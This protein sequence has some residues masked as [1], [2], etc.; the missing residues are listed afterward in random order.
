MHSNYIT[1]IDENNFQSVVQQSIELPTVF[2]F[3]ANV[4]PESTALMQV[5]EKIA[6]EYAGAFTLATIDCEKERMIASQFGV[7]DIPTIALFSQG[8]PID[9]LSGP[10]TEDSIRQMLAKHLPNQ[11]ELALKAAQVLVQEEK[12]LEAIAQLKSLQANL[13]DNGTFKLTL[14][15]C[16]VATQQF[17]LA[18]HL[19]ATVL[20]QDQDA[21]Y[22]ALIA[23]IEL[24]KQAAD[25]PEMRELQAAHEANPHDFA[26]SYE[27]ALKLS[28]LNKHEEALDLLMHILRND[29]NYADG[30][31]KK[32]TMDIL[33]ALGQGNEIA[34][35]F[36][37][38]LYA[39][40]Y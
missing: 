29:L 15:T 37:R 23:K 28:Q 7:Q 25:T 27:Y 33:A 4:I 12:Y 34:S 9:G 24:F 31:A 2:F 5:L 13:G 8:R 40:L 17:D 20:M 22:K 36:R 14:A 10:Q 3:W 39:L 19:L 21:T 26:I 1:S 32:T 18:E 30:D 16:Y 35:R 6:H 38:Q 11:D